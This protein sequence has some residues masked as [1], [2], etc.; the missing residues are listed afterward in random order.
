M[1]RWHRVA[2]LLAASLFVAVI[3]ARRT[4]ELVVDLDDYEPTAGEEPEA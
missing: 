3:A 1:N 2:L 4:F